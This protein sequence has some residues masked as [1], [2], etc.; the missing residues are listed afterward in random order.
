MLKFS[1]FD[2]VNGDRK[3]NARDISEIFEG[4]IS[5]G[6]FKEIG[7]RFKVEPKEGSPM[8][9]T[10]GTGQGWFNGIKVNN[11]T[12]IEIGIPSAITTDNYLDAI[13]LEINKK[14][15]GG[16]IFLM[17]KYNENKLINDE[18]IHQYVLALIDVKI[19]ITNITDK[20]ISNLVGD[21]IPYIEKFVSGDPTYDGVLEIE[22]GGTGAKTSN[23]AINNLIS[24]LPEA[25]SISDNDDLLIERGGYMMKVGADHIPQTQS[26]LKILYGSCD[27]LKGIANKDFTIYDF[28]NVYY[29]DLLSYV[30]NKQSILFYIK[31]EYGNNV[32]PM[33]ITIK[34]KDKN[35]AFQ[36]VIIENGHFSPTTASKYNWSMGSIVPI[37]YDGGSF[38]V[39]PYI[40][41]DSSIINKN[42]I[43]G[44][45]TNPI[46]YSSDYRLV[47][48]DTISNFSNIIDWASINSPVLIFVKFVNG[49]SK[50]FKYLRMSTMTGFSNISSNQNLLPTIEEIGEDFYKW[51]A[52]SIVPFLYDGENLTVVDIIRENSGSDSNI[53]IVDNLEST[54]TDEA[55]SA[56]QGRVLK[57]LIDDI[58][59]TAEY[60]NVKKLIDDIK[61]TADY[62]RIKQLIDDR[63]GNLERHAILDSDYQEN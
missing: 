2:S 10:V 23:D 51:K 38:N 52:N 54:S 58:K 62:D 40:T 17:E 34:I 55:L 36:N 60:E 8:W 50:Y 1:F 56:N 32:I 7:D 47:Y 49:N 27:T 25:S 44:T 3:Y 41:T 59:M 43:Y 4:I 6:V 63:I 5:D 11:T 33:R 9:I 28:Q 19:G 16:S 13:I 21:T 46:S 18:F 53:S 31:F 22:K 57:Q 48:I 39:I 12:K 15:R 37:L 45:C 29:E 24:N 26:G 61:I 30:R 20:D 35:S 14:E 42:I